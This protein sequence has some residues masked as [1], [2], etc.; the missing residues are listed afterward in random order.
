MASGLALSGERFADHH[1][2]ELLDLLL[3]GVAVLGIREATRVLASPNIL[4]N[5]R[6]LAGILVVS[7]ILLLISGLLFLRE[8]AASPWMWLDFHR[9]E[10][11][12]DPGETEGKDAAWIA[13]SHA[14]DPDSDPTGIGGRL[15]LVV[16]IEGAEPLVLV[17]D[18]AGY[19]REYPRYGLA[20]A[21]PRLPLRFRLL[22]RLH[23]RDDGHLLGDVR[24]G[25][26]RELQSGALERVILP[27]FGSGRGL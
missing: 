10:R 14:S 21:P 23:H 27:A 3:I 18:L 5:E 13:V 22:A 24:M 20:F 6:A 12:G 8:V 1:Y 19:H 17:E 15:E 4:R 7:Q 26:W 9:I 11:V 2:F 16:G 25:E